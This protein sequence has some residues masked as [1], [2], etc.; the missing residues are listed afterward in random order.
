M[1]LI[2][3]D[4]GG[5]PKELPEADIHNAVCAFVEDL[6]IQ[7]GYQGGAPKHKCIIVWELEAKMSDGR[8]FMLSKRYTVS[9]FEKAT[10]R[11][12]LESWRGVAFTADELKGFDL[13]KLKGVPCRL[14]VVHKP[15]ADG[16]MKAEV[17]SVIKAAPGYKPAVV[18]QTPPD[19]I[20]KERAKAIQ[21]DNDLPDWV[22]E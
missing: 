21:A 4:S 10:L 14:N 18:N 13:S 17:Q 1:T 6:G 22:R 3:S 15:K 20:A 5:G 9:L 12:D 2:A 16:A 8:P 7:P 19:W 11:H